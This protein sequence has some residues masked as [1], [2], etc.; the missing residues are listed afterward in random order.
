MHT[1]ANRPLR[2]LLTLALAAGGL[3]GCGTFFS[4]SSGTPGGSSSTA[5]TNQGI[6]TTTAANSTPA[7]SA[8][9]AQTASNV[10][11]LPAYAP[12]SDTSDN[13]EPAFTT[14]VARIS[15]AEEGADFDPCSSPDGSRLVFASTQHRQTSD[16]YVKRTDSR[17]VTQ[18]TNDPADDQMPAVSPDGSKIAFASNRAGNWDIFVMPISGGK[19]VQVTSDATDEIHPSWSP[20]GETLVFN[21]M[22]ESSG[23]WEMWAAS[24]S[25]PDTANFIGYG[26][27]PRWCPVAGT[28]QDGSDRILFQLPRER[29]RRSFGLWTIDIAGTTSMNATEIAGSA[30]NALINPTWSP[31][32]AWIVYAEVAGSSGDFGTRRA[33]PTD[34]SLWMVSST[35]DAKVR[36]TNGRGVC[37]SPAWGGNNRLFFVSNR[38]GSDNIW[39]MD[40]APAVRSARLFSGQSTTA[41]SKDTSDTRRNQPSRTESADNTSVV[42]APESDDE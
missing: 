3:G 11:S 30:T 8:T 23:R 33:T 27:F 6:P 16:L 4:G 32:G 2:S 24:A 9:T 20:D 15:F 10:M 28:G 40:M 25:R 34:S 38:A 42:T 21:R 1:P 22:G 29:G 31:D 7:P 36:L 18:L 13:D 39:A 17:V 12:T 41:Y 26:L 35:G 19:A 37:L 14:N 5:H